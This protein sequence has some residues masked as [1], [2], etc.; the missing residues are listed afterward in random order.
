MLE[1]IIIF[2]AATWTI[3]TRTGSG[4][5]AV[6]VQDHALGVC[7]VR[8]YHIQVFSVTIIKLFEHLK[9]FLILIHI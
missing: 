8:F 7:V 1:L 6:G 2:T 4:R 5:L 3:T 9:D